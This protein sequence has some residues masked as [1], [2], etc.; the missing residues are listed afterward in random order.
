MNK[1]DNIDKM[2]DLRSLK[3]RY[4]VGNIPSTLVYCGIITLI[5]I[6]IALIAT[7]MLL[8]FPYSDGESIFEHIM[9]FFQS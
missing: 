6:S 1:N 9:C 7:I 4:L 8:P 5:V 2:S 3:V